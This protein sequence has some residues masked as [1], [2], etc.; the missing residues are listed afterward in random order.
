MK[1]G[2]ARRATRQHK[3]PERLQRG[4]HRVDLT[5]EAH[6]LLGHDPQRLVGQR[7]AAIGQAQ[8]GA[9]IEQI[10]LDAPEHRVDIDGGII[11]WHGSDVCH[12][13]G[14]REVH[15]RHANRGVGLV[16]GAVCG[17]AQAILAD[18]LAAAERRRPVVAGAGIDLVQNNH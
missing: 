13:R 10:V 16:D 8:V 15:P 4:I 3:R 7:L 2:G 11:G 5:L 9:E 12:C 1:C 17:D 18:A 6:D 14:G